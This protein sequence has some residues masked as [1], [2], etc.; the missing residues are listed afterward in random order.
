MI[1]LS[2]TFHT[3]IV[4]SDIHAAQGALAS[5]IDVA[6]SPIR[7]FEPLPFWTPALGTHDVVVSACYS[8]QG[9][10][11]LE[12]CQGTGRFYDPEA[13]PDARHIGVWVDDL[14]AETE[15]LLRQDWQVL[16]A[17]AAP[18]EGYGAICYMQPGMGGLV[19]ELVSTDLKPFIEDWLAADA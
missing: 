5:S 11:H 14:P 9:P 8:R 15:Q 1:N 12:L 2:R 13:Q 4:V 7:T 6:W 3:G 10:V 16:A 18:E 17:G 19:I